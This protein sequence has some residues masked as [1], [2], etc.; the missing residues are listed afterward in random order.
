METKW[1]KRAARLRLGVKSLLVYFHICLIDF[2][3]AQGPLFIFIV[4][5]ISDLTEL[6][7]ID[8]L[9]KN[10]WDWFQKRSLFHQRVLNY[11]KWHPLRNAHCQ[12][13]NKEFAQAVPI[14][15]ANWLP[16][17]LLTISAWIFLDWPSVFSI[18][19]HIY[20]IYTPSP[21]MHEHTWP[22]IR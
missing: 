3:T 4:L 5:V 6:N 9:F 17:Q 21:H 11:A 1:K 20:Y 2:F 7:F 12:S 15:I 13:G 8:T 22:D 18:S 19:E 14:V 16:S 10:N